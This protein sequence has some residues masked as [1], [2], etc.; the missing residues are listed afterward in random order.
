MVAFTVNT[1]F[2]TAG[3]Y[4]KQSYEDHIKKSDRFS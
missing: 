1:F 4:K 3:C 2:N